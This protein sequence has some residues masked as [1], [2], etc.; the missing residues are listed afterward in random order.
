MLSKPIDE[1]SACLP[2]S[3]I[4][5]IITIISMSMFSNL[6]S[7]GAE[8]VSNT[9]RVITANNANVIASNNN[10]NLNLLAKHLLT[11]L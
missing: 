2:I 7:K 4:I 8:V 5:F 3:F 11:K 9:A 6:I 10:N 1:P